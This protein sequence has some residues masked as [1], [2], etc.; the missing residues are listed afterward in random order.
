[1]ND[2][3][4]AHWCN[5]EYGQPGKLDVTFRVVQASS[6]FDISIVYI[7]LPLV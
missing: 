7:T 3:Q 6:E 2:V 5:H 4:S 1:M